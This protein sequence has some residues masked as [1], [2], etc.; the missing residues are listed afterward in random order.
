MG[1]AECLEGLAAL[2]VHEKTWVYA[3]VLA[4]AADTIHTNIGSP[5]PPYWHDW[6]TRRL[7]AARLALGEGTS[8]SAW[9]TGAAMT[10]EE[11]SA[12]AMVAPWPVPARNNQHPAATADR[13]A[14]KRWYGGLTARE[15]EI[16]ALVAGNRSNREI[17]VVLFIAEKTVETHISHALRKLG[18]VARTRLAE[19]AIAVGLV[20]APDTNDDERD[21]TSP[22]MPGIH[23]Q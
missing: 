13:R 5:C 15:R 4:G 23:S 16:A 7:D 22:S 8:E 3:L 1:I 2:A 17:A 9:A 21:K 14:A 6:L 11:A 20:A 18:F 19:W 12:R 10:M